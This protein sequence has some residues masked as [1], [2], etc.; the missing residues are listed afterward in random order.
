MYS[1]R[2]CPQAG[3]QSVQ[4]NW[5]FVSTPGTPHRPAVLRIVYLRKKQE[6]LELQVKDLLEP[7]VYSDHPAAHMGHQCLFVPKK[8]GRW[9]LCIDY[10]ALNKQTVKDQVPSPPYRR[11]VREV[12]G[13]RACFFRPWTSPLVTIRLG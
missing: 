8:D 13:E 11:V 5:R 10:R 3:R 6:E 2:S 7:A 12:W 9:R 4:W 1:L